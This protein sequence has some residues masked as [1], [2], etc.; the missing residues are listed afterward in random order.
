MKRGLILLNA[1]YAIPN[2]LYQAD[3]LQAELHAL[4]VEADVVRNRPAVSVSGGNLQCDFTDYDFCIYLDKDKYT[5]KMLEG[6]GLRLF[7]RHTAVELCDD[8]MTTAI[9][10][11]GQGV[12]MPDTVPGLLCYQPDAAIA[13]ETLEAVERKLGYPMV[14]KT[15]YGSLGKGVY[16][17]DD[18]AQLRRIAETVKCQPHLFQRYLPYAYGRDIRVIVVGEKV[19]AAMLRQSDGD[20]RSNLELGGSATP[21]DPPAE[22]K[23]LSLKVAHILGLDYCGVDVLFDEKGYSVCE[24]NSNAF[25]GGIERT[26]GVNVARA[27]AEHICRSV[28]GEIR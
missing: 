14:V 25:F 9:A 21:F 5:S 6:H 7:N 22:L 20:F 4:G 10:L 1:Y 12:P 19:V 16:K 17:A 8:K 27:Y 28:Y 13:D 11:A 2:Y 15:S 24:V 3:R 23:A 18:R 26:T